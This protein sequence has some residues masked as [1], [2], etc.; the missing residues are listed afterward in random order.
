MKKINK[1]ILRDLNGGSKESAAIAALACG[2]VVLSIGFGVGVIG[3]MILGPT[4]AGMIGYT[5]WD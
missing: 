1:E 2:G 4:C 5:I 3:A